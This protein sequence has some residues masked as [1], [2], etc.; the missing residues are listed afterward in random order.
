MSPVNGVSKKFRLPIKSPSEAP[1]PLPTVPP[2]LAAS[3]KEEWTG[4]PGCWGPSPSCSVFLEGGLPPTSLRQQK[5]GEGMLLAVHIMLKQ[6]TMWPIFTLI[7]DPHMTLT[8][9]HTLL[10]THPQSP[11]ATNKLLSLVNSPSL[12]QQ[13]TNTASPLKALSPRCRLLLFLLPRLL[14]ISL[15]PFTTVRRK[16]LAH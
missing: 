14:P 1:S 5:S 9:T 2:C 16:F 11:W 12:S 3:W 8:L 13:T 10:H 7:P 15:L 6:S 4:F